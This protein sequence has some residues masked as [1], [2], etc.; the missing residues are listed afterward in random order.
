VPAVFALCAVLGVA[1]FH[2]T[3]TWPFST[4]VGS[5]GDSDEY[6]WFLSWV[7]FSIGHG[8]DP[9]ISH[10]VDFPAGANLM[11]NTSVLLPGF[12]M[13]PLTVVFGAA[14]SYNVLVTAAPVLCATFAYMA[15]RRWTSPG[16]A[17][18]G[19]LVFGFSPYIVSQS[20]GH[21]SQTLL[22]S[23]PLLLV[24]FDR[25]LVVQSARPWQDG[26]LLGLLAWA[27]LLTGEEVLAM[28]AVTAAI[29]LAVLYAVARREVGRR[30]TYALQ[31]SAVAAGLFV[32]LSAPFLAV[33]YLGPYKVE[34]AHPA[35][36]YVADLLNFVIPTRSTELAPAAALHVSSHFTGNG[37]EHGAYM[38]IPLVL[39][40]V[41]ALVL[42]RRRTV[43]WVALAVAAG[44]ALLSMGPTVHVLG[45]V[46]HVYLPDFVLQK[47]PLFDNLL[48]DRFASMTALG[49]GLLVALGLDELGHPRRR[50]AAAGRARA[51]G[52]ARAGRRARA[53]GWT[54]AGVGLVAIVPTVHF[55]SSASPLFSAFYTGFAC[56][57]AAPATS[58]AHP[59]VAFV[60]PVANELDLRWQA[61]SK[62]C[63]AMPSATGMTGT[64]RSK[65]REKGVLF[66]AGSPSLP[67]PPT[68]PAVRR[69]AAEEIQALGVKEIVVGPQSP[70]QPLWTYRQQ[71]ELVAWVEWL[72]GQAPRQT[73]EIYITYV[74]DD[75][76]PARDIA[77]G[78]VSG[79]PGVP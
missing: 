54:L 68:T 9:L 31:G 50:A 66:T 40:I 2:R 27:Q 10:Y 49:A 43:T 52:G 7:P 6:S 56:P 69:E 59:P 51:A 48:P 26:L 76:P 25:L 55:P 41:L 32:V 78:H 35:N 3:W 11:W 16:P 46:S 77:S 4:L 71:A 42:A 5:A 18:A 21:L 63:F 61:E 74:W 30:L 70:A 58:P 64:S 23:A 15:F 28:E 62:F 73:H 38:G 79:V 44:A 8:L 24:A 60:L 1:L 33:Q 36:R 72:L 12:L 37:S 17:L 22:M 14:F 34:K 29:A 47:L 20:V 39:F 45:H 65:A 19:A 57:P 75:L 13:S 67:R 53:A